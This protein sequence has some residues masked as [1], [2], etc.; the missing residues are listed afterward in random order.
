MPLFGGSNGF[1]GEIV[2][3]DV[4]SSVSMKEADACH[5]RLVSSAGAPS[6]TS[7]WREVTDSARR[8]KRPAYQ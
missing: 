1:L 8:P 7:S 5:A 4:A 6:R 2:R 3:K